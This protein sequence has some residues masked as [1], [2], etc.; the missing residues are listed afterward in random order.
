MHGTGVVKL[1]WMT[2]FS[3]MWKLWENWWK[4]AMTLSFFNLMTWKAQ[5]RCKV[6]ETTLQYQILSAI[7][8]LRWFLPKN[9]G[10]NP[11]RSIAFAQ[12]DVSSIVW[13]WFFSQTHIHTILLYAKKICQADAA[14]ENSSFI[15]TVCVKSVPRYHLKLALVVLQM[16]VEEFLKLTSKNG[17]TGG[18][19]RFSLIESF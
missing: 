4:N 1:W 9:I 12:L 17:E 10:Q 14:G 19:N 2:D 8:T 3:N 11:Y 15:F 5:A 7:G 6:I 13:S 16:A 18:F